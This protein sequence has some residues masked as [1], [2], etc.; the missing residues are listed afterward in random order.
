MT[1]RLRTLALAIRGGLPMDADDLSFAE[2]CALG[3][4]RQRSEVPRLG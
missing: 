2:W 1:S 3:V 4:I